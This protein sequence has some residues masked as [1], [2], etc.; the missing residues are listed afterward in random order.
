[1]STNTNLEEIIR[2]G[3]TQF[4]ETI[5]EAKLFAQVSIIDSYYLEINERIQTSVRI[6]DKKLSHMDT[7]EQTDN[8]FKKLG[9]LGFTPDE[10]VYDS[11]LHTVS[12]GISAYEVSKM[13]LCLILDKPN[14]NVNETMSL[15][16]LLS[17]LGGKLYSDKKLIKNLVDFFDV[18]FRNKLAHEKWWCKDKLFYYVD[19]DD[20]NAVKQLTMK[21]L[22][23]K[24]IRISM[25]SKYLSD[26]YI[27]K[28]QSKY[29]T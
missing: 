10:A 2:K 23:G 14:A 20:N 19:E 27:E 25:I 3:I 9:E 12:V 21:E 17:K 1:M 18:D 16:V 5:E 28:Y 6:L 15:G 11:L 29:A 8:Y 4:L 7:D 24:L 22:Q 26:I 13:F